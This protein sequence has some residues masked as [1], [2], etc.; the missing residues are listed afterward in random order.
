M[1]LCR[2][3]LYVVTLLLVAIPAG[4]SQSLE[5]GQGAV[6]LKHFP[7]EYFVDG[8]QSLDYESVRL[9]PFETTTS[10][11]TLGNR[12]PVAWY[13]ISLQNTSASDQSLFLHLPKAYHVR[14]IDIIEE[15][16]ASL[17]NNLSIDLNNAEAHPTIYKG[18]LVY[19]FVLPGGQSTVLYVRSHAYSHQWFSLGIYD[20]EHSRHELVG[21]HLDIALMVGMMLALVFY[22][23]LLYFATS[24]KENIFYSLY[25]ISG[26]VWIALSY[27]LVAKAFSAY[28]DAIFM[29]N[30][31]IISMPIFLLLFMMAI[32]ETREYYRTENRVLQA[33]LVPLIVAFVYG[34]FDITAVLKFSDNLAAL[35]MLVTFSVSLSLLRKGHPLVKFF[36][37]GHTFFL[38]FNGIAVMYYKG[39]VT[40]NYIN[41]HG[42]GIGIILEALTL[43]FII[44]YRIKL[45]EDIR[46][47]QDELKRQASTDPLTR[48]YNRRHFMAEGEYLLAKAKESGESLSVIALDIDHFKLVNDTHG[49]NVGDLVLVEVASTFR[50]LS[51]DRD[52]VARFGGEEFLILLPGADLDEA[53]GCA[54]RIRAAVESLAI[55]ASEN[56]VVRVTVS[57]GVVQ[58]NPTLETLE[59]AVNRTDQL[60]YEAKAAGRNRV[61]GFYN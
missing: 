60:L 16:S 53:F 4:A 59:D 42:V 21:S 19:P 12:A 45:L 5:I 7:V 56:V 31:S 20:E 57:L 22:N 13:R 35:V 28:G 49:H 29:L 50:K 52:L 46:S 30:L 26:L 18:T 40:P 58:V 11:A 15:R 55:A 38:I 27:G 41:S 6:K 61:S 36:L 51:R 17:V 25:L 8:S 39:M 33:M 14:S 3:F 2:L 48:L 10:T 24:K 43:A 23:S 9:E 44:S 47:K 1:A 37:V 54:E 34:L 32:F